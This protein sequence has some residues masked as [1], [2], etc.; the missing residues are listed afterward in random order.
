MSIDN[1]VNS[2]TQ[3]ENLLKSF[4]HASVKKTGDTSSTC[5][6]TTIINALM[7]LLHAFNNT[8]NDD[9]ADPNGEHATLFLALTRQQA[10]A[11]VSAVNAATAN[12]LPLSD[13][14]AEQAQEATTAIADAIVG[15]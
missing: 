4:I 5:Q 15:S 2:T 6:Q 14:E 8:E 1:F 7:P 11:L 9:L 10:F 12:G 3:L 13:A